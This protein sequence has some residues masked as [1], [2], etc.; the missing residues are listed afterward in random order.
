MLTTLFTNKISI[1][2]CLLV[3]NDGVEIIAKAEL[4][5]SGQTENGS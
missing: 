4:G 1:Q 2:I 3:S 5:P